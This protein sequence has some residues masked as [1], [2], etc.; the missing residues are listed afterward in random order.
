M[1]VPELTLKRRAFING[2]ASGQGVH[3]VD[4]SSRF[5]HRVSSGKSHVPVM[6]QR[7][8][9]AALRRRLARVDALVEKR[10]G[11]PETCR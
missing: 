11:G 4:H 3:G 1:D 5:L 7:N 6:G 8:G 10:S 2:R 9:L